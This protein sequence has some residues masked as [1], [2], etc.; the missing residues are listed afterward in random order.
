M[1]FDCTSLDFLL[2]PTI[3]E[4]KSGVATRSRQIDQAYYVFDG[5]ATAR[6]RTPP[7]TFYMLS[8][9]SVSHKINAGSISAPH[10]LQLQLLLH[11]R[12]IHAAVLVSLRCVV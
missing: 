7:P 1:E 3:G 4:V 12:S 9:A 6:V 10:Q 5:A 2:T 11:A 8:M